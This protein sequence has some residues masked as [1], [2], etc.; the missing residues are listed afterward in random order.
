M[1]LAVCSLAWNISSALNYDV[2]SSVD[3][4]VSV[5]YRDVF[6]LWE[7]GLPGLAAKCGS[8]ISIGG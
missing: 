8:T 7:G 2:A 6:Y 5:C 1:Q 3:Q 4:F